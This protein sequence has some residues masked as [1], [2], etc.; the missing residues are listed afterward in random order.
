M[1]KSIAILALSALVAF[2]L[3]ATQVMAGLVL[4]TGLAPGSA[5]QII[6]IAQNPI[7]GTSSNIA[8]YN[9][10]AMSQAA[11]DTSLPNT[12][13]NAVVSTNTVNANVNA[14]SAPGVPIYDT[15]GELV[16]SGATGLYTS[17]LLLPILYNQNGD[18]IFDDSIWTGSTS[19]GVADQPLGGIDAT[20]AFQPEFPPY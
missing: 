1:C 12:T 16:A 8:D 6:F 11:Q 9:A 13:W 14:P 3:S 2:A 5:Y 4:P 18:A 10:W 15:Q 20:I 19:A 17:N 7:H